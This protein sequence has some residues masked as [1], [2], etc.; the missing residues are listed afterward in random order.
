MLERQWRVE[1]GEWRVGNG[2]PSDRA[3]DAVLLQ[4]RLN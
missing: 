3:V 1:S 2:Q 4:G